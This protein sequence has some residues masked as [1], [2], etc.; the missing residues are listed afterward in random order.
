[1]VEVTGF[2]PAT[3]SSRTKYSTKLS[4]TSTTKNIISHRTSIVKQ[5]F[6]FCSLFLF[7]ATALC[8][9]VHIRKPKPIKLNWF[10]L[11][12]ITN[13]CCRSNQHTCR[14]QERRCLALYHNY[15]YL[16]NQNRYK[17]DNTPNAVYPY[18]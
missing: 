3:P 7:F 17:N 5:F 14:F 2:E 1:M 12:F 6:I 16:P 10:R 11:I 4:H 8:P 15:S 13:I 18:P 9:A